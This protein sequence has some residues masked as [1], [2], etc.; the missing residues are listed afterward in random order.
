[1]VWALIQN[2]SSWE[3]SIHTLVMRPPRFVSLRELMLL[4]WSISWIV[5]KF[6]LLDIVG[7]S[8]MVNVLASAVGAATNGV[9]IVL[10]TMLLSLLMLKY[11][12]AKITKLFQKCYTSFAIAFD[13]RHQINRNIAAGKASF[14][15]L[16]SIFLLLILLK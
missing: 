7:G 6:R 8:K 5:V 12:R 4:F 9:N 11:V 16:S 2:G 13:C 1:M 14:E 3:L 15:T 10:N